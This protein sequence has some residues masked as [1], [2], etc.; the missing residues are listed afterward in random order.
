VATIPPVLVSFHVASGAAA[1]TLLSSRKR[2]LV[3]GPLLHLAGDATPH[4]DIPSMR[5]ELVTGMAALLLVA[6]ARGPFDPATLGAASCSLPDIEHGLRLPRPR[7]RQLF[8]S[9]RWHPWHRSG[10]VGVGTQL[11]LTAV[12]LAAVVKPR[13]K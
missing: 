2:A 5:L 11:A 13:A 1:G 7:G 3:A 8:P 10:G 12:L 6:V 9:H 4:D